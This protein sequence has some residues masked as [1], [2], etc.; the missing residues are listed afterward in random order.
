MTILITGFEPFN[1][2]P[3][4][5]SERVVNLL[6]KE[7]FPDITLIGVI[8]PVDGRLGP[9]ALQTALYQH[10]PDAVISLGEASGNSQIAL[11]RIAIN[12]ADYR[13]PDNQGNQRVDEPI[14]PS[15]PTAYFSTLPLRQ[16][17]GELHQSGIPSDISLSAGAY[18]CNQ[19]FFTLMHT[20]SENRRSI[21]AGF[22]HL[23]SLPEQVVLRDR[24]GP[25]MS[26]HTSLQAI[27]IAVE[28]VVS[29][30]RLERDIK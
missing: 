20:L 1:G 11:E 16:I 28:V 22:I 26:L 27:K 29:N 13:I 3:I 8:L 10:Q 18:L 25:S 30:I 4:N 14:I 23:P 9:H 5:P 19:V 6:S 15:A 2:S 7:R 21:P 12:L 17:L 24:P